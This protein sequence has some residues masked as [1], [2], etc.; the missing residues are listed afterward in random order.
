VELIYCGGGNR[1]FAQI[2]IDHGY[3]YGSQLP[4]TVYFPLH[5][6]D[7]DFKRPNRVAYMAALAKHR[8]HMASVLDLEHESQLGEVLSWAEDAAAFVSVVMIVPKVFGI[9]PSIP[10]RIGG[11]EVR[12]GYSV[13]TKFGGT[14]LPV[15]EF[16]GWPVHLLG[17]QPQ[18]Q[19][20]LAH[21]MDVRSVDG[22]YAGLMARKFGEFWTPD[23]WVD[24]SAAGY[25]E[26]QDAM[27][28]AFRRSCENIMR[29]WQRIG[30]CPLD[31]YSAATCGRTSNA[32]G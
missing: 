27:Y 29:A 1:R 16:S 8:P 31:P 21:Y 6:A 24:L 22:N 4:E 17:G 20:E 12:L 11:A 30:W 18:A 9:I 5:F 14:E 19:M 2:A 23:G 26:R 10:R 3:L 7:Q 25:H 13:P 32:H 15:W 28:E